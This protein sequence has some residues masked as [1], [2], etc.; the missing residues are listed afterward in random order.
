VRRLLFAQARPVKYNSGG[1]T[2]KTNK[3]SVSLGEALSRT[4]ETA[5]A[6]ARYRGTERKLRGKFIVNAGHTA[7]RVESDYGYDLFLFTYDARGYIEPGI[8]YIQLKAA[9]RLKEDSTASAWVVR[10]KIEDYNLWRNEAMPVLYDAGRGRAYWLFVQ[11]YFND[12][13]SLEP[14]ANVASVTVYIPKN[15]RF[16]AGTVAYM[17]RRKNNALQQIE[18][19]VDHG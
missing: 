13:P 2:R 3:C 9:E 12:D 18:G 16:G 7:G 4:T 1:R 15:Q 14:R 17:R 10:M 19:V 11:K 6:A 5:H 8:V